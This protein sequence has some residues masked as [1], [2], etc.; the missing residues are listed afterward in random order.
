MGLPLKDEYL[1]DFP[2]SFDHHI[3]GHE[4]NSD[5]GVHTLDFHDQFDTL[6]SDYKPIHE[7]SQENY[8]M[9]KF[10]NT[11]FHQVP[12]PR[13]GELQQYS[14]DTEPQDFSDMQDNRPYKSYA[15][16]HRGANRGLFTPSKK[17]NGFY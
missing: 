4:V 3:N 9:T 13:L 17:L 6:T 11:V 8:D 16:S 14:F 12:S 10:E 5:L 15:R 1:A 7:E 2:S